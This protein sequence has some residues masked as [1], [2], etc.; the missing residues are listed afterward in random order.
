[1]QRTSNIFLS[2]GGGPRTASPTFRDNQL[3]ARI[4]RHVEG[5]FGVI[6]D[7]GLSR[8]DIVRNHGSADILSKFNLR[9]VFP[10]FAAAN[11]HRSALSLN[12][13]SAFLVVVPLHERAIAETNRAF[14]RNLCDLIARA[15]KCAINEAHTSGIGF[16]D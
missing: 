15:P 10:K 1:M 5:S 13:V 6:C 12:C 2:P 8:E 4:V 11:Q 7:S 16:F 3:I 9:L 14:A